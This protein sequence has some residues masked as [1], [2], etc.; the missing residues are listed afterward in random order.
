MLQAPT[1]SDLQCL[2]ILL[3]LSQGLVKPND[4]TKFLKTQSLC[5]KPMYN[6]F[7]KIYLKKCN[8]WN[9]YLIMSS[10]YKNMSSWTPVMKSWQLPQQCLSF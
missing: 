6:T 2:S 8:I 3:S 7:G 9:K 4:I 5:W 10:M 1:D